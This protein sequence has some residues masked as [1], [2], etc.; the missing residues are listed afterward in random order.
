[1]PS[2]LLKLLMFPPLFWNPTRM[3][4][5]F[6]T[7]SHPHDPVSMQQKQ[8]QRRGK[9][10]QNVQHSLFFLFQTSDQDRSRSYFFVTDPKTVLFVLFFWYTGRGKGRISRVSG[11]TFPAT[12]DR[13]F[14]QQSEQTIGENNER[15]E[16]YFETLWTLTFTSPGQRVLTSS[17]S[18]SEKFEKRVLPPV[19]RILSNKAVCNAV[20]HDEIDWTIRSDTPAWLIPASE[21]LK[22][23]SGIDILSLFRTRIC[24]SSCTSFA[25]SSYVTRWRL[26]RQPSIEKKAKTT[27]N[28]YMVHEFRLIIG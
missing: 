17:K 13:T 10:H 18:R 24:W 27:S 25:P 15:I 5:L 9:S 21:G 14:Q 23:N 2:A 22:S 19:R 16:S 3:F 26:R 28:L 6:S 11:C 4:Y 20:G 12:C 1:M 7:N 8:W